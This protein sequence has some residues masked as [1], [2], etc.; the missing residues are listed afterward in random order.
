MLGS[1]LDILKKEWIDVVFAGRNKNYG[2]YELRRNNP[3][4]IYANLSM[5]HIRMDHFL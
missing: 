1:K 2:A 4:L 5:I 3:K